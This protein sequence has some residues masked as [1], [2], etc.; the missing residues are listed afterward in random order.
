MEFYLNHRFLFLFI[1]VTSFI[2]FGTLIIEF[3]SK[4]SSK[5]IK[6]KITVIQHKDIVLVVD[7]INY[8][9]KELFEIREIKDDGYSVSFIPQSFIVIISKSLLGF[10]LLIPCLAI[11]FLWQTFD[12]IKLNNFLWISVELI[13]IF[14]LIS[15]VYILFKYIFCESLTIRTRERLCLRKR[16]G[17]ITEF[18]IDNIRNILVVKQ[19][20]KKK[21]HL[22]IFFEI[23]NSKTLKITSIGKYNF[24]GM[25]GDNEQNA[26][27]LA[28]MIA[29]RLK[30]DI[31]IK[32]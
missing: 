31:L 14:L 16:L 2:L 17:R 24:L 27:S 9:D 7:K 25:H 13:E 5:L 19:K 26:L 10:I 21:V 29:K 4:I 23:A 28:F 22:D 8:S 3:F 11:D 6:S 1:L 20:V 32:E 12:E 30:K 18:S 15:V